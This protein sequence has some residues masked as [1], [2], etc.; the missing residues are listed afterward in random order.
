MTVYR[1]L[2]GV[3]DADGGLRGEVSY[4]VGHLLHRRECALCD[5]THTWRRKPEWDA[6]TAK[7][8][9][10]FT[11]LHRNEVTDASARAA[12]ESA[13]LPVV[14]GLDSDDTWQPVLRKADLEKA[15]GSVIAFERILRDAIV[16]R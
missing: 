6:M 7:L 12:A 16:R 15:D 8:G 2:L 3:Y 1:Q 14:L 9:T 10:P 13:G 5:I 4:V 11:L